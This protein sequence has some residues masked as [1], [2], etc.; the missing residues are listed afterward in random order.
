MHEAWG[1]EH[2]EDKKRKRNQEKCFK[3]KRENRQK[4]IRKI[5]LRCILKFRSLPGGKVR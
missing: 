4:D 5:R 3:N 2:V 1:R